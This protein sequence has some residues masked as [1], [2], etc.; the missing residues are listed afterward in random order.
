VGESK[1]LTTL[2]PLQLRCHYGYTCEN[3]ITRYACHTSMWL[4]RSVG[5][6]SP[7][8]TQSFTQQRPASRTRQLTTDESREPSHSAHVYHTSHHITDVM[9]HPYTRSVSH[10]VTHEC[11]CMRTASRPASHSHLEGT[12]LPAPPTHTKDHMHASLYELLPFA[13]TH[14]HSCMNH[15]RHP[16]LAKRATSRK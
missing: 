14:T 9:T 7:A 2:S 13:A 11:I 6:L 4:P 15:E 10:T 5:K 1:V 8:C 12:D 16:W 3:N